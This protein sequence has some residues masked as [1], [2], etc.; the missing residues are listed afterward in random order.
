M[1][2]PQQTRSRIFT[3]TLSD[4]HRFSDEI[5][6]E[7][8]EVDGQRW[9]FTHMQMTGFIDH[10]RVYVECFYRRAEEDPPAPRSREAPAAGFGETGPG[11]RPHVPPAGTADGH[12]GTACPPPLQGGKP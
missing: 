4:L 11:G 7:I 5:Q 9:R 3:I 1:S 2:C 8:Y 12:D 6:A 10:E